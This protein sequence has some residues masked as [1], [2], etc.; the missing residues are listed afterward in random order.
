MVNLHLPLFSPVALAASV[1]S[2]M[3]SL[4][5]KPPAS[6]PQG[7]AG[8]TFPEKRIL[9]LRQFFARDTVLEFFGLVLTSLARENVEG[10]D[11]PA[12]YRIPRSRAVCSTSYS[13]PA[14]LRESLISL[15]RRGEDAITD[16]APFFEERVNLSLVVLSLKWVA[17]ARMLLNRVFA[18]LTEENWA[19]SST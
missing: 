6:C 5:S 1:S 13:I 17:A 2:L 18:S 10:L 15:A 12:V 14:F 8:K 11:L 19:V 7:A 3:M 16:P 4:A 9:A